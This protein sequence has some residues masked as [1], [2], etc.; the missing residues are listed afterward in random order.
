MNIQTK[1]IR[2]GSPVFGL[3][4]KLT[5]AN[6]KKLGCCGYGMLQKASA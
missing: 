6:Y 3:E 2:G 1:Q 4:G 5:T